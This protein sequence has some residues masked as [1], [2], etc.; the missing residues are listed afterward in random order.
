MSTLSNYADTIKITIKSL[1]INLTNIFYMIT[2]NYIFKIQ[3]ENVMNKQAMFNLSYGLYIL[4]AKDSQ[5]DN[6]CIVIT[7]KM[8]IRDR[9]YT[10]SVHIHHTFQKILP[11]CILLFFSSPSPFIKAF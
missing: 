11:Y 2:I 5:K 1:K 3:K 8:C 6:G 9:S 10:P 4:T 7:V